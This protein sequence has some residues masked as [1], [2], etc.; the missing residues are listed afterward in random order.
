MASKSVKQSLILLSV[1]SG[2]LIRMDE[3]NMFSV[4]AM[5]KLIR[6]T[7]MDIKTIQMQW[8]DKE[9]EFDKD[10]EDVEWGVT[11]VATWSEHIRKLKDYHRVPV[12]AVVCL[13]CLNDLQTKIKNTK[14][15]GMLLNLVEPLEKI[16]SFIDPTGINIPAYEKADELMDELYEL[17]GW[18]W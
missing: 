6:K 2:C 14:K 11:R 15:L 8:P 5:K 1:I 10:W 3:T 12:F 13:R 7:I 18:E 16:H 9:S 4:V 17:I